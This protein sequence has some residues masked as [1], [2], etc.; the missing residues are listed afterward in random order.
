M[1]GPLTVRR[2]V[3]VV[4][5]VLAAGL[6]AFLLYSLADGFANLQSVPDWA[7]EWTTAIVLVFVFIV[8]PISTFLPARTKPDP[9]HSESPPSRP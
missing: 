7:I 1:R 2:A 3:A 4:L 9:Q 6:A 8:W 5:A